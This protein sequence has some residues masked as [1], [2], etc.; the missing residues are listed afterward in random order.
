MSYN[1]NQLNEEKLNEVV[2]I[3]NVGSKQSMINLCLELSLP[4]LARYFSDMKDT[5]GT[6]QLKAFKHTISKISNKENST[7]KMVFSE[8]ET[9]KVLQ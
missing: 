7:F 1:L 2:S 3:L 6:E 9:E 8:I 5:L 4:L